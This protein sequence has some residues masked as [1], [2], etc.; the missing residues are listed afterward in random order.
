MLRDLRVAARDGTVLRVNVVLPPRDGR[1][2]VPMSAHPYGKDNLP[3]R[4]GRR[5]RVSVQYRILRQ[6]SRVRFSSL[7]GWEAPDPA[8]W[9]ARDAAGR[10]V[11]GSPLGGHG[12]LLARRCER[13][14][15]GGG[16]Q[17]DVA[18]EQAPEGSG[19]GVP[20]GEHRF[21]HAQPSL[22]HALGLRDPEVLKVFQG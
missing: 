9:A 20:D 10:P 17:S 16:C 5:W 3:T 11:S 13:S 21:L 2:P 14:P 8:W 7:T 6:T 19:V 1:F 4:R 15:V 22:Q 18:G 12:A